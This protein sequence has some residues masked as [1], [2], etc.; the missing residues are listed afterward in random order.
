MIGSEVL[1]SDQLFRIRDPKVAGNRVSPW[2]PGE[3]KPPQR[4][5]FFSMYRCRR[6]IQNPN[7]SILTDLKEIN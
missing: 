7:K 3:T 4:L 1:E 2:V 5:F 6:I